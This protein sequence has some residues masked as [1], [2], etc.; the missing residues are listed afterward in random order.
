MACF[1]CKHTG[2]RICDAEEAEIRCMICGRCE[3]EKEEECE[4]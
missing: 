3:R 2:E 4:S 1:V